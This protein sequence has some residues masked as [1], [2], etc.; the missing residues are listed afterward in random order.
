MSD[1]EQLML[2]VDELVEADHTVVMIEHNMEVIRQA[3]LIIDLGPGGG[4][5]GGRVIACASPE[6]IIELK[7]SK[8]G[9]FLRSYLARYPQED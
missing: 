1:V 4:D 2:V 6:R 9:A 5:K 3:D 7:R 8:T